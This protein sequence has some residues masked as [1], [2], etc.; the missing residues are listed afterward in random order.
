MVEV[1][2]EEM[3]PMF[4]HVVRLH[5]FED[6][7]SIM[8]HIEGR[9]KLYGPVG[10]NDGFTPVPTLPDHLEHVVGEGPPEFKIVKIDLVDT[11]VFGRFYLDVHPIAILVI[12][13]Q[14]LR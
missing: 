10:P 11:A 12:L 2:S 1:G 5:S 7:L 9:S 13:E 8:K 4:I 6:L 14:T 3:D